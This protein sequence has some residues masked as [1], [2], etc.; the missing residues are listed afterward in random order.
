MF[1]KKARA[2][3]TLYK[4]GMCTVKGVLQDIAAMYV[5]CRQTLINNGVSPD[6]VEKIQETISAEEEA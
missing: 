6:V 2:S 1:G 4:D 5:A 3:V